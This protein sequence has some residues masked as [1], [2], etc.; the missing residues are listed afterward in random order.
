MHLL[1]VIS[2]KLNTLFGVL[3]DDHKCE[4][5]AKLVFLSIQHHY[6]PNDSIYISNALL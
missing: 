6:Y 2:T 5:Y 1:H 4:Y 3:T